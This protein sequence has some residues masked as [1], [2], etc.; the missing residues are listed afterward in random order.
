MQP[1]RS[2][3]MLDAVS[4]IH[5]ADCQTWG[6]GSHSL[7]QDAAIGQK[8]PDEVVAYAMGARR[9]YSDLRRL[10]GQMAGL[11]IL[12]QASDR[13]DA[14]DLPTHAAA[15]ELW[16]SV[17]ERLENLRVPRRLDVNLYHLQSAHKLLG[18]C[19]AAL[20][21]PRLTDSRLDLTAAMAD[22]A[23]AYTH[24]QSASEPRVGMTMVEFS[25]ACCNC[26]RTNQ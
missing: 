16:R 9:V 24:L 23:R 15:N 21:A 4:A 3:S 2:Q 13:R 26:G 8:L 22:L 5:S 7:T 12:A 18:I 25:H 1:P 19:L 11:L 6:E 14:F 20:R 17:P 10:V